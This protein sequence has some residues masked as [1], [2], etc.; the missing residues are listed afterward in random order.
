MALLLR[1]L[2]D[3]EEQFVKLDV[4]KLFRY[5]IVSDNIIDKLKSFFYQVASM[6]IT[7]F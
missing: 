6:T 7:F 2:L 3:I 5:Q 4:I 1:F